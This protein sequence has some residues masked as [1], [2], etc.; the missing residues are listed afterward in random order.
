M[1]CRWFG[2]TQNPEENLKCKRP[3]RYREYGLE[4]CDV[5]YEAAHEDPED[6]SDEVR[7]EDHGGSAEGAPTEGG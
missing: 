5:H 7:K 3:A 1:Q 4:L 2:G 6:W